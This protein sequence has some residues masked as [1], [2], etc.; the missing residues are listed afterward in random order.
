MSHSNSKIPRLNALILIGGQSTRMGVDKSIIS[1][2]G[3]P[4]W[5][6]LANV[7]EYFIE[8]V[9]I[10]VRTDQ[11]LDYPNL[12]TD[13]ETGLG[14]FGGILSAL[15]E[16]PNEAFLVIATD[17]PF[18]D[19]NIIKLLI[20]NRDPTTS[21][22]AL[23]GKDN[24]YPEPL[25]TIWEPKSITT[26]LK[27]YE[28]GVYKPIQVLKSVSIKKVIV[29]NEILQNINTDIEYKKAKEH[30]RNSEKRNE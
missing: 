28:K 15:E 1:Y 4:Q 7:L 29:P 3:K 12:I 9:Y 22:T 5:Q 10:S 6:Y 25:A 23:Q 17:L 19:H 21:A 30:F 8:K 18:I 14:P 27:F 20:E 13:I 2:H 24:D 16:K 26:L 11:V